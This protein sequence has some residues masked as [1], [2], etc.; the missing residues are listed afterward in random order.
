MNGVSAFGVTAD[1]TIAD[2]PVHLPTKFEYVVNLKTL[3]ALGLKM[4]PS[5]LALADEVIE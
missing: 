3:K 4:P 5:L 1:I 2:L